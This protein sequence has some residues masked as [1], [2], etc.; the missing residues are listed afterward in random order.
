MLFVFSNLC[1]KLNKR[2]IEM[3]MAEEDLGDKKT[4]NLEEFLQLMT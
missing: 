3:L 4:L 2:D 1:K